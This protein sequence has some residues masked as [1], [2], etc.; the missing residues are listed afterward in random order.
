MV[1]IRV[2]SGGEE[3]KV[4]LSAHAISAL[5]EDLYNKKQKLWLNILSGSMMPLL[6]T[7]DKVLVHTVKPAEIRVGDIIVFKNS[8]KL[9]VHRV[10]RSYNSSSFLQKGD[11]TTTAEIVSSKDVIG[12]VI[13]IRKGS[14][15]IYPDNGFGKFINLM[16][17]FFS[18]LVYYF[19]PGNQVLKRIARYFF[20][21]AKALLY[22]FLSLCATFV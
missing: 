3:E 6:Q 4:H 18:C 9:I 12:K 5:W 20:N 7:S 17:T 22:R 14:R 19:K 15:I 13:A 21:N 1:K 2:K 16:L 8:D 10:I 11:N